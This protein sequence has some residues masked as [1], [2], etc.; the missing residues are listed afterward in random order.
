MNTTKIP[1][2]FYFGTNGTSMM[3]CSK[4]MK[5]K[6]S[7]NINDLKAQASAAPRPSRAMLRTPDGEEVY[8]A[9]CL[10]RR[11][12]GTDQCE[13]EYCLVRDKT[14]FND[15]GGKVKTSDKNVFECAYR[16]CFEEINEYPPDESTSQKFYIP[17]AK[18]VLYTW[19]LNDEEVSKYSSRGTWLNLAAMH[20]N[21]GERMQVILQTIPGYFKS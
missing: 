6:F 3:S 14:G 1:C 18:Y 15:A 5:C 17:G 11:K 9:G 13:Y 4:G 2:A 8:G 20:E 16:E 7:H 21:A 19:T 10:M 12:I